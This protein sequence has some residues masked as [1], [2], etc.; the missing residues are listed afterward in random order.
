MRVINRRI[1]PSPTP[2]TRCTARQIGFCEARSSEKKNDF[3]RD[4]QCLA[5]AVYAG[6]ESL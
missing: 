6:I 4:L 5:A 3:C 2:N 1:I